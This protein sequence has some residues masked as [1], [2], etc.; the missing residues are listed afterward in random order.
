M[1]PIFPVSPLPLALFAAWLLALCAWDLRARRLPNALTLGGAA[2][3]LAARLG[4]G[5]PSAA[6]FLDG[7]AGGALAA[8]LLLLPFLVR[9]AGAGDVKMLFAAGCA[10]GRGRA[11]GF[12]LFVSLA[13]LALGLVWFLSAR[14]DRRRIR[15]LART[16]FDP[17]YDRAAGRAA[18]PP[19][20]A[21]ACRVPF[22]LAIAAG[23]ALEL[24]LEPGGAA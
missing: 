5:W 12:L 18:L 3:A 9:A 21:E 6:P 8:L 1:T 2:V 16:L 10:L 19:K 17:R 4:A 7:L 22:G 11:A 14:F 23:A 15:H 24:A 13:G 20:S